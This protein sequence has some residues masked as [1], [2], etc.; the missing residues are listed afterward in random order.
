MNPNL[1]DLD[2]LETQIRETA[3]FGD[4]RFEPNDL[5]TVI[6]ECRQ[7]RTQAPSDRTREWL[8]VD[9]GI[10]GNAW[11][12]EWWKKPHDVPDRWIGML[13]CPECDVEVPYQEIRE[14]QYWARRL[15]CGHGSY[16]QV[17]KPPVT[18]SLTYWQPVNGGRYPVVD[19]TPTAGIA[20]EWVWAVPESE[21]PS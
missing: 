1:I 9:D 21:E 5:L 17:T 2:R 11:W 6:A 7:L 15:R 10:I 16:F 20:S 14:T 4:E 18:E 8:E 12:R 3:D 19:P 13:H